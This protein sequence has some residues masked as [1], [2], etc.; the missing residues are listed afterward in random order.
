MAEKNKL[1]HL[2][3][4]SEPNYI[5]EQNL[6]FSKTLTNVEQKLFAFIIRDIQK[7]NHIVR[8]APDEE[9]QIN[10]TDIARTMNLDS[11]NLYL[12]AKSASKTIS[13]LMYEESNVKAEKFLLEN[14]FQRISYENGTITVKLAP[15][16][17]KIFTQ[18]LEKNYFLMQVDVIASFE[19]SK[20]TYYLYGFVSF[21]KNDKLRTYSDSISFEDLLVQMNVKEK[22]Y[23][24]WADFR[25][26]VLA[27]A[28]AE[29]EEKAR[30]RFEFKKRRGSNTIDYTITKLSNLLPE[31]EVIEDNNPPTQKQFQLAEVLGIDLNGK[32]KQE[33]II[34][35]KNAIDGSYVEPSFEEPKVSQ[36]E[37]D[38]DLDKLVKN[39]YGKG[40]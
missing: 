40:E 36:E 38:I 12:V 16:G 25:K 34:L 6:A 19:K 2:K 5:R 11:K 7:S 22:S 30:I 35:I 9:Y 8:K 33:A 23:Q 20:Y 26:R 4:I 3:S 18:S 13:T 21:K 15:L 27:P 17:Y 29:L 37:A 39:A 31:K 28:V 10:I 32:T 24:K 14:V 1:K